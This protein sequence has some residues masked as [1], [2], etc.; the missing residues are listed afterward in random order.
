MRLFLIAALACFVLALI[1]VVA[2][3]TIGTTWNGWVCAGLVSYL[4]ELCFGSPVVN[5][6]RT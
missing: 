2:T 5:G 4:L 3:T 6:P 1:C